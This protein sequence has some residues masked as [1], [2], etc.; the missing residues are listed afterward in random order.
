VRDVQTI[1]RR[2]TMESWFLR[3]S[4]DLKQP[5]ETMAREQDRSMTS[6]VTHLLRREVTAWRIAK[7]QQ[8]QPR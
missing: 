6:F 4:P 2:N 1:P 3:L 7:S 8:Q 5:V